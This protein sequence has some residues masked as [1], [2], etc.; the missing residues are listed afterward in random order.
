MWGPLSCY[1]LDIL[2]SGMRY[3]QYSTLC[4]CLL[5]VWLYCPLGKEVIGSPSSFSHYWLLYLVHA[6]PFL[7]KPNA[8]LLP[9]VTTPSTPA[10]IK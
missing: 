9:W 5:E 4:L 8:H 7:E 10:I 1:L 2:L 3:S 6:V